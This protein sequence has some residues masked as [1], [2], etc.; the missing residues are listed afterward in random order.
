VGVVTESL[1]A[2]DF[3]GLEGLV[4]PDCLAGLRQ[5]L[6][7]AP[8]QRA[9]LAVRPED[10]FFTFIPDF[11]DKDG[12]QSLLLGTEEVRAQEDFR[13]VMDRIRIKVRSLQS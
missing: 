4:S 6:A 2:G 3:S 5:N 12:L 9:L 13:I 8:D 7:L 10:V 11:R 1:V